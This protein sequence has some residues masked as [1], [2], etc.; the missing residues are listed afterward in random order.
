MSSFTRSV[1][2]RLIDALELYMNG[3]R[4]PAEQPSKRIEPTPASL[5]R[6]LAWLAVDARR[7][8]RKSADADDV[9]DR[10]AAS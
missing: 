4:R 1:A 5:P 2:E 3:S 9:R 10:K 7:I 6:A 8:L